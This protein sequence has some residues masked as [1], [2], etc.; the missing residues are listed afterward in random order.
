MRFLQERVFLCVVM[1]GSWLLGG[2]ASLPDVQPFT[3]ATVGLRSAVSASGSAVVGELQRV[4]IAGVDRS[5]A[6]LETA[7]EERNKLFTGLVEY[8]HSLR[9]IVAAG[10]SGAASALA[11]A[12]SVQNLAATAGF[13]APGGGAAAGAVTDAAEFI[14]ERI[15]I[16]RAAGDLEEALAEVQPAI[17]RIAEEIAKD[18]GDLDD[19][20]RVA[21]RA[22]QNAVQ[23]S[24]QREIAMREVLLGKREEILADLQLALEQGRSPTALPKT[25]ELE[26]VDELLASVSEASEPMESKLAGIAERERLGRRLIH[27]IQAG[28]VDWAMAHSRMLTAVRT[29]QLPSVAELKEAAERIK[30]I[31][32]KFQEL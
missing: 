28:V 16:A 32:E 29:K 11:V 17:E 12:D 19:L 22:Q 20:I 30:S 14:Y 26:A 18:M 15:A 13:A 9:E 27:E 6:A 23:E 7:W 2:C 10:K 8:G 1:S 4:D 31:V 21:S 25:Q 24:F 5:A 3:E